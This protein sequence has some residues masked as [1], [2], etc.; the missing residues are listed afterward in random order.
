MQ[1]ARTAWGDAEGRHRDILASAEQILAES[2]YPALTMRAIAAGAG[3]SS[4]TVYQYF[5]GKEDVFAALMARRLED[6]RDTLDTVDRGLGVTGVLC[7]ILPQVTELWRRLGRSA[8]QWEAKVLAGRGGRGLVTSA[9]VYRRTIQAL[10][11]ALTE[12]AAANGQALVDDPAVAFWVWDSLIGLADDLLHG[13]AA[14]G[15]VR[16][17]RLVEFATAA[18]ERGIVTPG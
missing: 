8:P 7:E 9:T 6:L 13:G 16:S 2:G 11:R 17:K 1:V 4:G 18:I 3:V 14:Q 10:A 5:A 15:K 12:T